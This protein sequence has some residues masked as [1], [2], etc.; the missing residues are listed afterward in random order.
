VPVHKVAQAGLHWVATWFI[1]ERKQISL[2]KMTIDEYK[3]LLLEDEINIG[4]DVEEDDLPEE[5][6]D[7][8]YIDGLLTTGFHAVDASEMFGEEVVGYSLY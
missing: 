7:E 8:S 4:Y 5:L 2:T 1:L 6:E 3:D